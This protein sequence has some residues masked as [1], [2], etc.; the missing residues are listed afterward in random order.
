MAKKRVQPG[1]IQPPLNSE[2]QDEIPEPVNVA[3][4]EYLKAMRAKN[5]LAEKE[6]LTREKCIETMKE[7]GIKKLRI[8]D[9]KQWL[10]CE[11]TN[12]LKTR[13]VNLEKDDGRQMAKA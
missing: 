6:R 13:K 12:R 9:G 1:G 4:D 7:H 2:W 10:E 3:V 8:D 5:K 11:D